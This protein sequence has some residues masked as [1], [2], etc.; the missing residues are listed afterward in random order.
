MNRKTFSVASV[1]LAV[2]T[3]G[4]CSCPMQDEAKMLFSSNRMNQVASDSQT[5]DIQRFFQCM[6]GAGTVDDM[7]EVEETVMRGLKSIVV[8]VSTNAVDDSR[9]IDVIRQG[10]ILRISTQ[11]PLC[12][13]PTNSF[14]CLAMA[15]YLGDVRC[16]DFP[17]N[18]ARETMPGILMRSLNGN[19][20]SDER[21]R[22]FEL[23]EEHKRERRRQL[24]EEC[25]L[26]IRVF[27]ANAAVKEYRKSLF[28][29]CGQSVAGCRRIM[30]DGEFA[31]FTN[32][33]VTASR[34]NDEEQ[35]DLF[36]QLH[37]GNR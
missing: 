19:R 8:H 31:S 34:A 27:Y 36:W 14:A 24:G 6:N 22:Q 35:K 1:A 21:I 32:A 15:R 17:S 20:V 12:V 23:E 4:L 7:R 3:T 29:L 9:G 26:Q 28:S 11:M 18:L 5:A 30:S 25:E 10:W 37:H 13:F 33:V 16:A 2:C